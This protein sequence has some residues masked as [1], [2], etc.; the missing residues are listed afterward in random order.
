MGHND[1]P[2]WK[3]SHR[4][5]SWRGSLVRGNMQ[6]V[7]R[8]VIKGVFRWKSSGRGAEIGSLGEDTPKGSQKGSPRRG[9]PHGG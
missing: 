9:V 5:Q 6:G 8:E 2:S 7:P 1:E 3:L 4:G